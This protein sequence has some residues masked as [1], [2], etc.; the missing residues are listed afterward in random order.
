M[1]ITYALTFILSIA[2][3]RFRLQGVC[4]PILCYQLPVASYPEFDC[5][6]KKPFLNFFICN[7]QFL[8]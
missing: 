4:R 6:W 5:K 1:I 3:L 7:L 2:F 8:G